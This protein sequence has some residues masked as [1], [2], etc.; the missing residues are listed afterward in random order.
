ML[1][2][3]C[4]HSTRDPL[5][6]GCTEVYRIINYRDTNCEFMNNEESRGRTTIQ[7]SF[8]NHCLSSIHPHCQDWQ[9]AT[10]ANILCKKDRDLV[11]QH[12]PYKPQ[13]G[14]LFKFTLEALTWLQALLNE[15]L[16]TQ[17]H[18]KPGQHRKQQSPG[19]MARGATILKTLTRASL[20]TA[21]RA[22]QLNST[23]V[24]AS[25]LMH[26]SIHLNVLCVARR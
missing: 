17:Q 9:L 15:G 8:P 23:L 3:W 20:S 22:S 1:I 7:F 18:M 12:S 6:E 26:W 4:S 21:W 13:F 24:M 25:P 5:I 16:S 2:H 11:I 19:I 10:A 14:N